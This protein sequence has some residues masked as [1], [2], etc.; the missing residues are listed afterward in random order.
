MLQ[1]LNAN[2]IQD[3]LFETGLSVEDFAKKCKLSRSTIQQ[4]FDGGQV[5]IPTVSK[6]AKVL[7]VS[8]QELIIK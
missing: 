4:V 7:E 3:Y 1:K 2:K 8:P 5:R 6:I